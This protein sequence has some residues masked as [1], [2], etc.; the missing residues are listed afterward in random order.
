MNKKNAFS[1]MELAVV[2]SIVA[3]VVAGMIE[4]SRLIAKS[5]LATARTITKGSPVS[6]FKS[7]AF[8]LETTSEKSFLDSE[9]VDE[10]S[11]TAWYDVNPV[12]T[13]P[14]SAA[15][16]GVNRPTYIA[17]C[18]VSLPC[19]RFSGSNFMDTENLRIN[20]TSISYFIVLKPTE[21][22]TASDA[23][24][25]STEGEYSTITNS[26]QFK[27]KSGSNQGKIEFIAVS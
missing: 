13:T 24:L 5:K 21:L 7:L 16:S 3:I 26:V 6:S 11:I 22:P 9:V 27:I 23:S 15:S 1:L 14:K 20:S 17:N 4:G 12:T 18:I 10:G 25:I 2:L 8:W 19:L